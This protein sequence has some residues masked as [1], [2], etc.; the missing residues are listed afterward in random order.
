MKKAFSAAVCGAMCV[1]ACAVS[2]QNLRPG[3]ITIVRIQ[4]EAR[5]SLDGTTWHP[6][7]VG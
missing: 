1:L 2:A 6:L 3:I 5:Y 7:V 4:G